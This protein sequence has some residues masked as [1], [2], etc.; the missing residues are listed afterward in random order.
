MSKLA[1]LIVRFA[2]ARIKYFIKDVNYRKKKGD[3]KI[4]T[5]PNIIGSSSG[6]YFNM[7]KNETAKRDFGSLVFFHIKIFEVR[8]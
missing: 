2:F 3:C 7:E 4:Y 1:I 5:A 8:L 6:V